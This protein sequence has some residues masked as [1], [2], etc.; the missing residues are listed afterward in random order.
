MAAK[1]SELREIRAKGEASIA[2]MEERHKQEMN[3]RYGRK[4]RLEERLAASVCFCRLRLNAVRGRLHRGI[5]QARAQ[6]SQAMALG[7]EKID[8]KLAQIARKRQEFTF[9]EQE[10]REEEKQIEDHILKGRGLM[11]EDLETGENELM[12]IRLKNFEKRLMLEDLQ[13]FNGVLEDLEKGLRGEITV[14]RDSQQTENNL[15]RN[16]NYYQQLTQIKQRVERFEAE[17]EKFESQNRLL[18]AE[19]GIAKARME[20]EQKESVALKATLEAT[21]AECET[22]FED[23]K[24]VVQKKINI[25]DEIK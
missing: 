6:C 17:I 13:R 10:I 18:L 2:E 8:A 22:H 15:I 14:I 7:Q 23:V 3:E 11:A 21:Q 5:D 12:E 1:Q 19:I 9:L 25:E 24:K 16:A 4:T 20:E